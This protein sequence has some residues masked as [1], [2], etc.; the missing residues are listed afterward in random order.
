MSA[1]APRSTTLTFAQIAKLNVAPKTAPAARTLTP[2]GTAPQPPRFVL[3]AE[4]ATLFKR[5]ILPADL[6]RTLISRTVGAYRHKQ[7][8]TGPLP[9]S[10]FRYLKSVAR[11]NLTALCTKFIA[12]QA[13]IAT[14]LAA[15]KKRT[16]VPTTSASN[17]PE[18]LAKIAALET[19][20]ALLREQIAKP[21]VVVEKVVEKFLPAPETVLI[22]KDTFKGL[23]S[24]LSESATHLLTIAKTPLNKTPHWHGFVQGFKTHYDVTLESTSDPQVKFVLF[25]SG[26]SGK[27]S[28]S[29]SITS[30][31]A[32]ALL[33]FQSLVID[34]NVKNPLFPVSL[35]S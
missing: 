19:E 27:I 32:S 33:I 15:Q 12:S 6:L 4:Q 22:P 30:S 24:S 31:R 26:K 9:P 2:K 11:Q 17:S 1:Q 8:T 3:T 13:S 23:T 35:A 34:I 14:N 10:T 25:R 5:G 21:P 20:L 29:A 16:Q 7:P 28:S 18:L